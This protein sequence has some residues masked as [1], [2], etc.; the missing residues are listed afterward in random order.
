M[1]EGLTVEDLGEILKALERYL[2][3]E[4]KAALE[5]LEECGSYRI[6]S[7]LILIP[8]STLRRWAKGCRPEPCLFIFGPKS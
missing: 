1:S 4:R 6:V 5:L 7:E 3:V 2:E 8:V